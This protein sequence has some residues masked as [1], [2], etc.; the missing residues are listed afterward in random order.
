MIGIKIK[1]LKKL[2]I[3]VLALSIFILPAVPVSAQRTAAEC[4]RLATTAER[5]ACQEQAAA[6][7]SGRQNVDRGEVEK[8]CHEAEVNA[9]NCRIVYYVVT[10]IKLLSAVVGI[11]VVI[12]IALGGL[13]YSSARDNPQA[14][15]AARGKITNALIALVA[16]LFM[17]SF[18]QYLVPGGVL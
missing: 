11:V 16:Y 6:N 14:V 13:Q 2:I 15:A 17:F 5:Q 4:N 7:P 9:G 12:M 10:L 8:D 3:T 1:E 18:L